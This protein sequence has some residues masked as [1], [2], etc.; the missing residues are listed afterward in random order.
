[1]PSIDLTADDWSA[2][3]KAL[4]WA[5]EDIGEDLHETRHGDFYDAEERKAREDKQANWDRLAN[6][7]APL[8]KETTNA[9]H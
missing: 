8:A 7:L 1:M 6:L 2:I 4:D 3:L 9:N 5:S